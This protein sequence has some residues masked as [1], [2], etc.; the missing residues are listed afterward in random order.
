MFT[1][2]FYIVLIAVY[3]SYNVCS[4]YTVDYLSIDMHARLYYGY[5]IL[6]FKYWLTICTLTCMIIGCLQS[7]TNLIA[8]C[9]SPT[10][11]MM[12]IKNLVLLNL[13]MEHEKF[14]NLFY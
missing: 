14:E 6:K 11:E 13:K 5:V 7:F 12:Y 4:N 8:I 10:E 3:I 1:Y 2:V 9:F